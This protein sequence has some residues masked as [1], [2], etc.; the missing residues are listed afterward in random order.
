VNQDA[1]PSRAGLLPEV[2]ELRVHGVGGTPA[3]GLLGVEDPH[4]LVQV[5][6]DAAA[7]FM[8]RKSNHSV[9]GY[10]WGKLTSKGFLQPLWL[11]LLPFTMI[12]VAGWMHRPDAHYRQA[13]ERGQ[14]RAVSLLRFLVHIL[15]LTFTATYMLWLANIVLNE[16]ISVKSI[17]TWEPARDTKI[18]LGLLLL[19]LLALVVLVLARMVQ[20]GFEG[21][22]GPCREKEPEPKM[23]ALTRTLVGTVDD[24]LKKP[25]FWKR[26]RQAAVLLALH[27]VFAVAA[28]ITATRWALG[29][30]HPLLIDRW[31]MMVLPD[32]IPRPNLRLGLLATGF[33]EALLWILVGLALLHLSA[34]RVSQGTRMFRLGGP[35]TAAATGVGLGTGFLYGLTLLFQGDPGRVGGLGIAFGVAAVGWLLGA[36]ILFTKLWFRARKEVKLSKSSNNSAYVKENDAKPACERTGATPAMRNSM[37]RA[38]AFSEA[39]RWGSWVLSGVQ[40]LFLLTALLELRGPEA[41]RLAQ[42]PYLGGLATFGHWVALTATAGVLVFLVRRG[43]GPS[44]RRQIGILWDVLTFWPR[45][46]HPLGVRPYAERAVPELQHRLVYHA[47]KGHMI[48]LSAHSQGSVLAYAALKQRECLEDDVTKHIAL[49][50][51]G[52]PLWQL[53]AMAFPAYFDQG[54]FAEVRERLFDPGVPEN[55]G[56]RHFYRRTDYIGKEVFCDESL[57]EEVPDP[58]DEP[59]PALVPPDS[60][61][62]P[63]RDVWVDLARHSFYNNEEQLKDWLQ[64]LRSWMAA[65]PERSTP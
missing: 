28:A 38:R 43:F 16:M 10:V 37:A 33:T 44:Q 40:L 5:G 58:A 12:N 22:S 60:W 20:A 2:I 24:D 9:E 30:A 55:V 46:F 54:G 3:E 29:R 50:T 36:L 26:P 11:L 51:Y 15:A 23:M 17:F 6:G 1:Q 4:D 18:R 27:G 45:R 19:F 7:P 39:G 34:W 63:P 21:F 62:D 42:L 64:K 32:S 59:R 49:I 53:H 48:I 31:D 56:W 57:E 65:D 61:P 47:R 13:P 14:L 8:A 52:S 25:G 35:M 41:R